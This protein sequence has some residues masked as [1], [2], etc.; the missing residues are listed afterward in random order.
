MPF[1]QITGALSIKHQSLECWGYCQVPSNL[2]EVPA[3]NPN[4][5]VFGVDVTFQLVNCTKGPIDVVT[6]NQMDAIRG[7]PAHVYKGVPAK[8]AVNC[9]AVASK[10][11]YTIQYQINNSPPASMEEAV[12]AY[13]VQVLR[14]LDALWSLP[15]GRPCLR[16][17]GPAV[18]PRAQTPRKGLHLL[19]VSGPPRLTVARSCLFWTGAWQQVANLII[20]LATAGT[21]ELRN[22]DK[23]I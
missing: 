23:T 21:I 22:M 13:A 19:M 15:G 14:S 5:S 1:A 6:Y 11:P 8:G 3:A 2:P 7:V 18:P 12:R 16:C 20:Y 4:N 17:P 9:T 10:R